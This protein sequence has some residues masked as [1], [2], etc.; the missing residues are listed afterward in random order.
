MDLK[1]NLI[2]ICSTNNILLKF[3]IYD[4]KKLFMSNKNTNRWEPTKLQI[5]EIILPAY[6]DLSKKCVSYIKQL[7]C[8]PQYI[9]DMLS[10]LSNAIMTSYPEV[11]DKKSIL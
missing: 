1:I 3:L 5:D 4:K 6:T 2:R 8:P 11:D 7:D 10:D 9:A